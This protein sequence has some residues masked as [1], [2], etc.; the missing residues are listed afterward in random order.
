M[1][2]AKITLIFA[3]SLDTD[4]TQAVDEQITPLLAHSGLQFTHP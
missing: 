4:S 3:T 2:L 1:P